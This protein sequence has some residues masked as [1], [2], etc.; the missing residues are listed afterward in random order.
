MRAPATTES[1]LSQDEVAV[2][3]RVAGSHSNREI[4]E[5]LGMSITAVVEHKAQAMAKLGLNTR[6]DVVRYVEAQG[7]KRETS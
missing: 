6:I 7:W 5:E 1:E 2:L 4:V 3:Q